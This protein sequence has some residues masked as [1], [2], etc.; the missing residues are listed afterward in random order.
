MCKVDEIVYSG[1]QVHRR[2]LHEVNGRSRVGLS[3]E[4]LAE[5]E[6]RRIEGDFIVVG[7]IHKDNAIWVGRREVFRGCAKES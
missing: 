2:T 4:S 3:L 7:K 5:L 1:S 6:M